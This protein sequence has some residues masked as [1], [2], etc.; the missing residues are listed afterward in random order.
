MET[1]RRALARD[2]RA[3][4]ERG[5]LDLLCPSMATRQWTNDRG[6]RPGYVTLDYRVDEGVPA[7]DGGRE[8]PAL[9]EHYWSVR[10]VNGRQDLAWSP[11]LNVIVAHLHSSA[12]AASHVESALRNALVFHRAAYRQAWFDDPDR[13]RLHVRA[14][15]V[16]DTVAEDADIMAGFQEY[17]HVQLSVGAFSYTE[18]EGFR[19]TRPVNQER[20]WNVGLVSADASQAVATRLFGN[21]VL[22]QRGFR[23]DGTNDAPVEAIGPSTVASRP[24]KTP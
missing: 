8:P 11:A 7:P 17:Q 3:L 18:G 21:D 16:G 14:V 22:P 19:F 6:V 23:W 20:V 13:A 24:R 1:I 4:R 2:W 9:V 5:A 12:V 10:T 15:V